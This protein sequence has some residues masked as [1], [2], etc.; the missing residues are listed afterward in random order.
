MEFFPTK[1]QGLNI[2]HA[3]LP[4]LTRRILR[5][6]VE[7]ITEEGEIRRLGFLSSEE[8]QCDFVS[9]T[10]DTSIIPTN[11]VIVTAVLWGM[12]FFS[13]IGVL[14]IRKKI[15]FDLSDPLHWAVRAVHDEE[16]AVGTDPLLHTVET[17]GSSGELDTLRIT[18]YVRP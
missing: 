7:E 5:L 1:V 15:Y 9:E 2:T 10:T 13:W 17:L 11:I 14:G 18:G 8:T 12:S 4:V 16:E 3:D 6:Y